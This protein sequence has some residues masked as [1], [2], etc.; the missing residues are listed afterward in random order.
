M[1]FE[2]LSSLMKSLSELEPKKEIEIE[3]KINRLLKEARGRAKKSKCLFCGET[4][5]GFCNSHNVPEFCLRNISVNGYLYYS[6]TLIECPALKD[7][8]GLNKAGTFHRICRECDSKV[9]QDYENPDNL[10]QEP[11][12]KMLAE[13]ALKNYLKLIDKK[14]VEIEIYKILQQ[15][16]DIKF[17]KEEIINK[18]D[19]SNY[20]R[21]FEKAKRIVRKDENREGY[22]MFFH[23]ILDY[24]VP[25][26]FQAAITL[27]SDIE[28]G[29]INDIYYMNPN[30]KPKELQ[31]AIF[32]L[33]QKSVIML[34]IDNNVKTY[35]KF[36]K[37]FKTY[38]LLTQLGIINYM[39][40]LYSEDYFFSKALKDKIDLQQLKEVSGLTPRVLHYNGEDPRSAMLERFKLSE[41]KSI[42][43]LLDCKYAIT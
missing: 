25:I 34:F 27:A 15:E 17:E 26:A 42:P 10:L 5:E 6:N 4:V 43:N 28:G 14:L 30:Y 35:S 9:F 18:L 41:W 21:G 20:M 39:M 3:M 33:K 12:Q 7:S 22:Y 2:N 16:F 37:Q 31:V 8:K 38:P 19:Y 36:I 32:P 29:L 1:L 11:S 23:T 40:F 13:I 24:K